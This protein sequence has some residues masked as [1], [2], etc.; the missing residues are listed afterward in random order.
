MILYH[1]SKTANIE[2][3][4]PFASNHGKPYVY[5]T[6]SKILAAIYA[7]NPLTRPNGFFTYWWSKDGTLCYDEYFADQL[8]TIYAGQTGYVYECAGDYPQM[9]PMPWVYLSEETVPVANCIEIPD[10]YE[11]LLQYEQEGL[12]KV[13]RWHEVSVKQRE[14][15][16]NVVKRSLAKTD[17]TTPTGKEYCAYIRAHFPNLSL[18]EVLA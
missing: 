18:D 1:G 15:W 12:L 7:H 2:C 17:I 14:V 4:R 9:E 8:E 6:H 5:L 11:L 16:E 10:I 13:Q 3:L